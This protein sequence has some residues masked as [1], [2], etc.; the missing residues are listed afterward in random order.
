MPYTVN[1]YPASAVES[2]KVYRDAIQADLLSWEAKLTELIADTE[3]AEEAIRGLTKLLQQHE[4][5]IDKVS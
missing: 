2:L 1:D 5:A 3:E 4:T